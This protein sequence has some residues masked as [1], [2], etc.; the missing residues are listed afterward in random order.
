[1]HL[2]DNEVERMALGRRAKETVLSQMGA[3][4]RTV[5]ALQKLLLQAGDF[6]RA[7][8]PAVLKD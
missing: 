1:M 2:V 6:Q 8:A 4:S 3:T 7:S 5:E